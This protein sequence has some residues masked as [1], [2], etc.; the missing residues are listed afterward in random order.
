MVLVD[1]ERGGVTRTSGSTAIGSS[2]SEQRQALRALFEAVLRTSTG[3][4]ALNFIEVVLGRRTM[5]VSLSSTEISV[6]T[7]ALEGRAGR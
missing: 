7:K 5:V 6:V 2:S 1:R 3:D 4:A